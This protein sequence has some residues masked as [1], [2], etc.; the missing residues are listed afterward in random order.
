M[1]TELIPYVGSVVS[2]VAKI[3][4]IKLDHLLLKDIRIKGGIYLDHCWVKTPIL[5]DVAIR[6]EIW[7]RAKIIH[8]K[9]GSHRLHDEYGLKLLNCKPYSLDRKSVV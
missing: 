1:R 4:E 7:F 6:E 9:K 5:L 8:Y 3:E 2:G